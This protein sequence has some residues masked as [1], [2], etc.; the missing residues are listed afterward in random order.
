MGLSRRTFTKE[1]KL[2][3]VRRLGSTLTVPLAVPCLSDT[4]G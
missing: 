3:A 2:A 1:F 4:H